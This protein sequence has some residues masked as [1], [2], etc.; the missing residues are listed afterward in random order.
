MAYLYS[1]FLMTIT[2]ASLLSIATSNLNTKLTILSKSKVLGA[3]L[4]TLLLSILFFAPILYTINSL[5]ETVNAFDPAYIKKVTDFLANL[6]YDI[7]K[8][9]E[10]LKP[11]IEESLA[12]LDAAAISKNILNIA[13]N[14]G[15]K[16][17][18]FLTD[19]FLIIVFYFFAN[20]YGRDLSYYLKSATPMKENEANLIFFEITNVMS[21]VFYSI[22]ITAM[23][24]GI[25]FGFVG[26]VY[27]YDGLLLGILYG[28]ASLI[29]VV[30]GVLM[31]APISLFE[32]SS[33]H[34]TAAIVI[35]FYSIIVISIIAD[36][37]IKPIII[38]YINQNI[39][40][41]STKI[42][43]LLIF[44]AIIAG[45]STFGFWGMILGP[46][47]T[48]LFISLLKLFKVLKN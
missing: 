44:F 31:W 29:P 35:A 48:T 33:G 28:F 32:L 37:F 1:P 16:S 40:R 25:L 42:N 14:I 8:S 38:K 47:I 13:A 2:I 22:L 41:E 18:G 26:M 36:T 10:F 4:S 17:A 12:N 39:V 23:F 9:L 45:I 24:E 7:P 11:K 15:K 27:G 43:E 3:L 19:M 34:I 20:L 21:V 30:G 46:A 5:A 6:D